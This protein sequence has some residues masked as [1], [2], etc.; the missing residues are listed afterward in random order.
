[1]LLKNQ[2]QI[3][4]LLFKCQYLIELKN[5]LSVIIYLHTVV[6]FQLFLSY[7]IIYFI[8]NYM[9]ALS[10]GLSNILIAP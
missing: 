6:W 3:T 5:K 7:I 4:L 9:A 10:A 2:N 1:M 8:H